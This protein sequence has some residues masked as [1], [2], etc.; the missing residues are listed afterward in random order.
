[1]SRLQQLRLTQTEV[2]CDR[3][4]RTTPALNQ[5]TM[6][7]VD[8]GLHFRMVGLSM[9]KD[10]RLRPHLYSLFVILFLIYLVLYFIWTMIRLLLGSYLETSHLFSRHSFSVS[11]G[12]LPNPPI[13]FW[14]F[15][16][17]R[18]TRLFQNPIY[19]CRILYF[20]LSTFYFLLCTRR[21]QYSLFGKKRDETATVAA[22]PPPYCQLSSAKFQLCWQIKPTSPPLVLP[23]PPHLILAILYISSLFITFCFIFFSWARNYY[24]I[25]KSISFSFTLRTTS[26]W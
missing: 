17:Q 12:P 19:I 3:G 18:R 22:Y 10:P 5:D 1:M 14:N 13:P 15:V 11:R 7:G 4:G 8:G 23:L 24:K 2:V 21:Q 26:H 9:T 20:L 6:D 16:T 25:N